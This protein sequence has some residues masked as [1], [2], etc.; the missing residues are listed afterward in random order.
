M[1]HDPNMTDHDHARDDHG[2]HHHD[3]AVLDGS[4]KVK[5]PVCGMTV[6]PQTAKHRAEALGA[7][8]YFC[9]SKCREKF[10]AEPARAMSRKLPLAT[11][12]PP[13]S[14]FRRRL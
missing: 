14:I 7:T 13:R 5:D 4:P 3:A 10:V 8:Y 9:S 2:H 6:D 11:A 12:W 1:E